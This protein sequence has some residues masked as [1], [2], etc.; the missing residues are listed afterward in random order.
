MIAPE[1]RR[2]IVEAGTLAPSGDNLQPWIVRW[3]GGTLLVAV[4]PDR[5]R[6]LYN[7]RR[8]PSLIAIGAFVENAVI[9]ARAHGLDAEVDVRPEPDALVSAAVSFR[10]AGPP[11]DPLYP[12]IAARSTNRRPYAAGP[13]PA[14]VLDELRRAVPP[15]GRST[16]HLVQD[17]RQMRSVARAASLNDRLLFEI[18]ALHRP[19]FAC[20]RWTT[21]EAER[22]G[23][24][25]FVR[26]LELGPMAAGFRLM[27][28]WRVAR[29]MSRLGG[30]IVAPRH[31]FQTFLR[32][33]AFGLLE[34]RD[35]SP[36]AFFEGGRRMQRIWLTATA[37]GLSLQP[38]AGMLYLVSYLDDDR[39]GAIFGRRRQV[40]ERAAALL[41]AVWPRDAGTAAI[42]IFRVG[43]GP[44]PSARSLR[45]RAPAG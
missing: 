7:V 23:D 5:D 26:T 36:E 30:G 45:R 41:G 20:V 1:V 21:G 12:S 13:L 24:G 10:A 29:M 16:L 22:S 33:A 6:S 4:D 18:E 8:R 14:A 32:S 42:M 38:M 35:R 15:D 3:D 2:T 28:S 37:A 43:Y 9:A 27:R 39:A 11:G 31:S 40:V 25:L 19:F 17:P 44:P 34:M